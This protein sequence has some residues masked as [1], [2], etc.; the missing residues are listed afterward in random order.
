VGGIQCLYAAYFGWMAESS[1]RNGH[2]YHEAIYGKGEHPAY[3]DF[4]WLISTTAWA[5]L[6]L[7]GF[8]GGCGLLRLRS[9]VR[10]GE[11]VYLGILTAATAAEA[12]RVLS[13]PL[14]SAAT[15]LFVTSLV[16][17]CM[18]FGLFYV[19]FLFGRVVHM[20]G[21]RPP[22]VPGKKKPAGASGDEYF[23]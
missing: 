20:I 4:N 1:Y 10:R 15:D 2:F 19:P 9:W 12:V 21:A 17:F 16:L 14:G 18:V 13:R 23:R 22:R 3:Y 7:S 6:S 11:V 8:I 5:L